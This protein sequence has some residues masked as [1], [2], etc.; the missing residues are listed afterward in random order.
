M[1]TKLVGNAL[2]ILTKGIALQ[3]NK[4]KELKCATQNHQKI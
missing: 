2:T 1:G 4:E 3:L